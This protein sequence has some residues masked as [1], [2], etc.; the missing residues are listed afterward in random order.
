M[1]LVVKTAEILDLATLPVR[2][3]T[4]L[5]IKTVN[6]L[7]NIGSKPLKERNDGQKSVYDLAS[8]MLNIN[9][10]IYYYTELRSSTKKLLKKYAQTKKMTHVPSFTGPSEV[11]VLRTAFVE[12][13][14]LSDKLKS[15]KSTDQV[16]AAYKK[17]SKGLKDL[18][19]RY[20]LS[21]GDMQVFEQYFSILQD[22]KSASEMKGD[23]T[24]FSQFIGPV[25]REAFGG[26]QFNIEAA[27]D[28]VDKDPT[29]E[30]VKVD[31]EFVS[32]SLDPQGF[33]NDLDN[34][35]VYTI[36]LSHQLKYIT[37]CFRGSVNANDWITNIQVNSTVLSL[38]GYTENET[39]KLRETYPTYGNVHRGFYDY[40]FGKTAEGVGTVNSK[41]EEIM[42]KLVALK[43]KYPEY[44]IFTTGHSLGG[45]LS[46][47]MAFRA[48]TSDEF[49]DTAIMNVS[50]ASPFVGDEK[51]RDQF[52]ELER[53]GRVKH[54]RVSND[55]DVVPLIPFSTLP[56]LNFETYKQ[57]GMNIRLY[58]KTLL[59]PSYR[60]FYPKKN[61]FINGVKD[62][63]NNFIFQGFSLT[64]ILKHL[65]PLYESRLSAAEMDLKKISL[66]D[67]YANKDITGWTMEAK[68]VKGTETPPEKQRPDKLL[69]M[70]VNL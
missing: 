38:P 6:A 1:A 62:A 13:W 66:D 29:T 31:D 17:S 8:P 59:T 52:V 21:D 10:L 45:A 7:L 23:L 68:K 16:A 63:T 42:G 53:T 4:G 41:S 55:E 27:L 25:F 15:S 33:I 65:C 58:N 35:I 2:A 14:D 56:R 19:K 20:K 70:S 47:L 61:D 24:L 18:Q 60:V 34:E 9:I 12:H 3:S 57:T 51:F 49:K 22:N 48:A 30:V 50:F 11:A 67:L 44:E 36:S 46:T 64:F 54:L 5:A 26:K 39:A 32:T 40:L 28:I 37:V 69:M 43:K